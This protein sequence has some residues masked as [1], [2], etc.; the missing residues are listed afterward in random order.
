MFEIFYL[1]LVFTLGLFATIIDN[2]NSHKF[3]FY[4]FRDGVEHMVAFS[5][6]PQY[7][8][9]TSG[10]SFNALYRYYVKRNVPLKMSFID[11]WPTHPKLIEVC[12]FHFQK[13][14]ISSL[15]YTLIK[16]IYTLILLHA[17]LD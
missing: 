4:L 7:S 1:T 17:V 3:I 12:V 2:Y 16:T 6:Y 11:R 9:S 14:I 13:L 15:I 5:Q 10:S 8:C